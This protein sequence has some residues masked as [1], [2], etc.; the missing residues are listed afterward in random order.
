M[1]EVVHYQWHTGKLSKPMDIAV[2]SDLH[3]C[4]YE[5]LWPLVQGAD[6]L[7]VPG[8]V[9]NRYQQKFSKGMRFLAEAQQRLPTFFSPGNHEMRLKD[10]ERVLEALQRSPATVL[11]NRYVRFGE[12]WLG[13]WY[14]PHLLEQKDMAEEFAALPGCKLMLCHRPEDYMRHLRGLDVDLV[15]AGH[16]HGGQIRI[17]GQGLYAPGQGIFPKWTRGLVDGRMIVCAG[18]SNPVRIPRWGNPC[19]VLRIALD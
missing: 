12:I 7:L 3:D 17:A 15:L 6:C 4:E 11:M 19:E 10:R 13:G 14:R 2:V 5:D 16:A 1:R 9:A 18:A 8:D